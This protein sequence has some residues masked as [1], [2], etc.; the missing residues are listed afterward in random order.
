MQVSLYR[1]VIGGH[2]TAAITVNMDEGL[3][4]VQAY[5]ETCRS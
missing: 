3:L 1:K 2:N 5:V 4:D